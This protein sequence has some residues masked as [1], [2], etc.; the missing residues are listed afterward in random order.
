MDAHCA[1]N[2]RINGSGT[3]PP[4]IYLYAY[5]HSVNNYSTMM[6]LSVQVN[7][8]LRT[9]MVLDAIDIERLNS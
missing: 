4:G 2:T 3:Q 7:C 1:R 8:L 6:E 9:K 5:K